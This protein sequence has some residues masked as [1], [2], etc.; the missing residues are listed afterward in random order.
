VLAFQTPF[1]SYKSIPLPIARSCEEPRTPIAQI[2]HALAAHT[3]ARFLNSA[4]LAEAR[5]LVRSIKD[6]NEFNK[7]VKHHAAN[8][9]LPVV[10]VSA[11]LFAFLSGNE[12]TPTTK[13]QASCAEAP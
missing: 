2:S 11:T 6:Q 9:G 7:L 3:H 8:T 4:A 5:P 12:R 1:T 10:R 13:P